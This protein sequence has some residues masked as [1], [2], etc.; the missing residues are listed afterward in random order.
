MSG[1]FEGEMFE[2]IC[3]VYNHMDVSENKGTPKWMVENPIKVDDL[4]YHYFRKHSHLGVSSTSLSREV[5][6]MPRGSSQSV[7]G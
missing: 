4:G 6:Q 3:Q 1:N 5:W 2:E 7:S